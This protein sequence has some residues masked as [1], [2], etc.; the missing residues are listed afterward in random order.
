MAAAVLP[1]MHAPRRITWTIDIVCAPLGWYCVTRCEVQRG[2]S[3]ASVATGRTGR[4]AIRRDPAPATVALVGDQG[5]AAVDASTFACVALMDPL[6]GSSVRP[7]AVVRGRRLI[8]RGNDVQ[9][10]TPY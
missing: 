1:T 3:L 8:G 4:H 9:T 10:A 7:A 2:E 5:R 6:D